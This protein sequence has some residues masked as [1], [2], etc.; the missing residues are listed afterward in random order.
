MGASREPSASLEF[1]SA[2]DGSYEKYT[3]EFVQKHENNFVL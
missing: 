2:F 1:L 3:I